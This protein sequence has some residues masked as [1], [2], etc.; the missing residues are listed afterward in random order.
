MWCNVDSNA[1]PLE[2][3][4]IH[5][6]STEVLGS[7]WEVGEQ[8]ENAFVVPLKL[9]TIQDPTCMGLLLTIET[10]LVSEL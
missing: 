8:R 3:L 1:F 9:N 2:F 10:A 6:P 5:D 4:P 7:L